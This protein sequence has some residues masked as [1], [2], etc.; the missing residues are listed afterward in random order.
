MSTH[1]VHD[2]TAAH[3]FELRVDGAVAALATYRM[4]GADVVVLHT[5]T[6]PRLR[7]RGLAGELAEQTLRQLRARGQRIV[8]ACPFFARYLAEHPEHADLVAH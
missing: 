5:E 3:R 8:P 4:R 7:G 6:D 2:N 1:P